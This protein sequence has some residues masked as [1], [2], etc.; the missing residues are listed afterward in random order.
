[1]KNPIVAALLAV[2]VLAFSAGGA[3]QSVLSLH[4]LDRGWSFDTIGEAGALFAIGL[5]V[6]SILAGRAPDE[7]GSYRWLTGAAVLLASVSVGYATLSAWLAVIVVR[8]L[9]GVAFGLFLVASETLLLAQRDAVDGMPVSARYTIANTVGNIAGP[10]LAGAVV[11]Y[12]SLTGAFVLAAGL[13][14]GGA[15]IALALSRE[16]RARHARAQALNAPPAEAVHL[17]WRDVA[18][19]C[20]STFTFGAMQSAL[21]IVLPPLLVTERLWSPAQAT[22]AVALFALGATAVAVPAVVVARRVGH[23]RMLPVHAFASAIAGA[24]LLVLPLSPLRDAAVIAFFGAA[25]GTMSPVCLDLLATRTS[26]AGL[27]QAMSRYNR[28]YAVGL[29][30]GAP[31]A[32]WVAARSD[33]LGAAWAT[34]GFLAVSALVLVVLLFLPTSR[35][36]A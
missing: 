7:R 6:G 15:V 22:A 14:C 21:L 36:P 17:R 20:V 26:G 31:A 33:T 29:L 9:E 13:A 25:A 3:L 1:M 24:L 11:L 23:V 19:A 12:A 10:L 32:G 28:S 35:S 30:A 34:S 4:L 8:V 2:T 16:A 27:A 18:E 5:F